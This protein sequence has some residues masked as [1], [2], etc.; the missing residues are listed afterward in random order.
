MSGFG[1]MN[2]VGGAMFMND[3][4]T[5]MSTGSTFNQASPFGQM[6][7]GFD[8]GFQSP[9]Q[10]FSNGGGGQMYIDGGALPEAGGSYGPQDLTGGMGG[11]DMGM[12][13]MMGMHESVDQQYGQLD[14]SPNP[15]FGFQQQPEQQ[16]Y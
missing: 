3:G 8:S 4:S 1:P 16:F 6:G 11:M 2:S 7:A 15:G 9:R 5:M 12:G 10:T 14:L 13:G